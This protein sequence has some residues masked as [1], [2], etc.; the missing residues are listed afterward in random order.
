MKYEIKRFNDIDAAIISNEE[1]KSGDWFILFF[2]MESPEVLKATKENSIGIKSNC[3]KIIATI[4]PFKLEGLPMLEL[5]KIGRK[6]I[7]NE[8]WGSNTCKIIEGVITK[9]YGNEFEIKTDTGKTLLIYCDEV[10]LA[11]LL[12]Q[13]EDIEKL[14]LNVYPKDMLE[15]SKGC[16]DDMNEANRNIW[17]AGYKAAQKQYSEEDMRNV[18]K[19]AVYSINPMLLGTDIFTKEENRVIQSLQKKQF[20]IAVE[21]NPSEAFPKLKWYYE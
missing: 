8:N 1:I 5:S 12:N 6:V 21:F 18:I 9:D 2:G 3:K 15:T 16:F 20:P 14:A 17:I 11:E 7:P 10:N 13:E 4:S 19:L